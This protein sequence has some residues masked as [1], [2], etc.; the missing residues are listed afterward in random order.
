MTLTDWNLS[1]KYDENHSK[2]LPDMPNMSCKRVRR[3]LWSNVLNAADKSSKV[4]METR[5]SSALP[6]RQ[7]VT[8]RS[9]VSIRYRDWK[10]SGFSS[11]KA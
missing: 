4:R 10:V 8:S 7:F 1:D 3:M 11:L 9:A 6:R 5:P 2:A